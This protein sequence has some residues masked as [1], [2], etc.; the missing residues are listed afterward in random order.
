MCELLWLEIAGAD[1]LKLKIYKNKE[2]GL[3][4]LAK[5]IRL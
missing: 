2:K 1:E 4:F 3:H 5:I